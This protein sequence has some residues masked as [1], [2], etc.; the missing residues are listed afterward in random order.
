MTQSPYIIHDKFI[1][2]CDKNNIG[3]AVLN[4][5]D[6]INFEIITNDKKKNIIINELIK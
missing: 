5:I 2:Y 4:Q 6:A 3:N 1:K